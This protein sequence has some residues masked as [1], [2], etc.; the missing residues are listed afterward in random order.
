M[1]GVERRNMIPTKEQLEEGR[2]YGF[3]TYGYFFSFF[4]LNRSCEECDKIIKVGCIAKRK[5]EDLQT[6]RILRL[7]KPESKEKT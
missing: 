6:K 1:D 3:S 7:C 2:H 5:I 4:E